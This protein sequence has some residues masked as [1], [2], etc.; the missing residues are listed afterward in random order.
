[1][2]AGPARTGA[3]AQRWAAR[4]AG[5]L[6]ASR[7]GLFVIAVLTGVG[8]GL[9][10]VVFRYL[11]YFFTWLFTGHTQFGQAGYTG[12]SHLPWLGLAFFVVV[13]VIGGIIY[14]P[15]I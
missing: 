3:P 11:I 13:P 7:F 8:A 4:V 1:M 14:G 5:W 12:S 10:A 2:T 6:R 15:L 9:G